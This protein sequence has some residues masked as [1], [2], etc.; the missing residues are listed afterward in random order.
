MLINNF[1]LLLTI[2]YLLKL[3][4]SQTFTGNENIL[5]NIDNNEYFYSNIL[6]TSENNFFVSYIFK[7]QIYS[8][9]FKEDN[10]IDSNF[11]YSANNLNKI[12]FLFIFKLTD[13][14]IISF[15]KIYN[16]L[17]YLIANSYSDFNSTQINYKELENLTLNINDNSSIK[18]IELKDK[19]IL[20]SYFLNETGT[21]QNLFFN[22]YIYDEINKK[23]NILIQK[24]L[25]QNFTQIQ[26]YSINTIKDQFIL[27]A[28]DKINPLS[29]RIE[30]F[31]KIINYTE[32]TIILNFQ[33]YSTID[34]FDTNN[35]Q[36]I[37]LKENF[38]INFNKC[39]SNSI[40]C[41]VLSKLYN[42]DFEVLRNQIEINSL[43]NNK[44]KEI[45]KSFQINFNRY[46]IFYKSPIIN[47]SNYDLLVTI[48]DSNMNIIIN[49]EKINTEPIKISNINL[50]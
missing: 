8:Q 6:E 32:N 34:N 36:I 9:F 48:L 5:N 21:T 44:N 10:S 14:K 1:N 43:E 23:L 2:M 33:I 18:I 19:K 28:Y 26:N 7:N 38:V 17:F 47:S 30:T 37:I 46:S 40:S 39:I 15:Y 31:L 22:T 13:G 42:N 50:K 45:I 49:L 16:K 27:I 24:N 12:D 29:S 25:I 3:G 41:Q 35:P 4:N 11:I 20:I